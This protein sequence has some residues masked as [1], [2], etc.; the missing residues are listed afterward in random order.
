M[1]HWRTTE[2]NEYLV[3]VMS[4][5]RDIELEVAYDVNGTF[6]VFEDIIGLSNIIFDVCVAQDHRDALIINESNEFLG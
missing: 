6:D 1:A 2:S 5:I 4:K 3:T